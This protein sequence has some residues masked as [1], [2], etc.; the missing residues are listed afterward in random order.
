[1]VNYDYRRKKGKW[2]DNTISP[3][4]CQTLQHWGYRLTK[5]ILR[6]NHIIDIF[7]IKMGIDN[8]IINHWKIYGK[9]EGRIC[10]PLIYSCPYYILYNIN[11]NQKYRCSF[12][13]TLF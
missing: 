7:N 3:K 13:Y 11:R 6:K 10:N 2:N 8:E 4:I 12:Q 1:M 5:K 9:K